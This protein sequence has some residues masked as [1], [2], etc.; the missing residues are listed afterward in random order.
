MLTVDPDVILFQEMNDA[1]YNVLKRRL[2]HWSFYHRH[3]RERDYYVLTAVRCRK[4][5]VLDIARSKRFSQSSQGRHSLTVSRASVAFINVHAESGGQ[6]NQIDARASQI[7]Y[8]ARSHET[9]ET[10]TTILAGD[11]NARDGKD[12]PLVNEGWHDA[13]CHSACC[14][15]NSDGDWTWKKGNNSARYDRVFFRPAEFRCLSYAPL[16]GVWTANLSDHRPVVVE[17]QR[18]RVGE[19]VRSAT[20]VGGGRGLA[21][22]D[23]TRTR[24][25]EAGAERDCAEGCVRD[26]VSQ[27]DLLQV[28]NA[29]VDNVCSFR[30]GVVALRLG[31]KEWTPEVDQLP[32]TVS[33]PAWEELPRE[34]GIRLVRAGERGSQKH[35][36][37]TDQVQLRT[38]YAKYLRW[39]YVACGV[40]AA[41]LHV[42]LKQADACAKKDRG[43]HGL[44]GALQH[45]DTSRRATV[46]EHALL[47]CRVS[48]LRRA[49]T[50]AASCLGGEEYGGRAALELARL[51]DLDPKA[52]RKES[53]RHHVRFWNAAS[54]QCVDA[55][56][57]PLS[58]VSSAGR[59]QWCCALFEAWVFAEAAQ[60]VGAAAEWRRLV[61]A[62]AWEVVV[63]PPSF[64]IDGESF[65]IRDSGWK[66]APSVCARGSTDVSKF[67]KGEGALVASWWG[68]AWRVACREINVRY[69][70]DARRHWVADRSL[71]A[72][73]RR[74]GKGAD[75]SATMEAIYHMLFMTADE[76]Q[77]DGMDKYDAQLADVF[78]SLELFERGR[79]R[80]MSS[81]AG[82]G[83]N[84]LAL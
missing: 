82:R 72:Q 45:R 39:A 13:W 58:F 57:S 2:T 3:Q 25:S 22:V 48:G 28:M 17:L 9:A 54:H 76:V 67:R 5:D 60:R 20:G 7:E 83:K 32:A 31:D 50:Q 4:E 41:G 18:L 56:G 74:G 16:E 46:Q 11:F 35:V 27:L 64:H 24:V 1:M 8:L 23:A 6:L 47:L 38:S 43:R 36:T 59:L 26:E 37:I 80:I 77:E 14:P 21:A 66:L 78:N 29:A 19:Q 79:G 10:G 52:L 53:E 61:S 30:S 55:T 70:D 44:P 68:L 12:E 33:I 75:N 73:T 81:G 71:P 65:D 49:A 42:F 62:K 51:L 84:N 34:G 63:A 69:G 40:D 15:S